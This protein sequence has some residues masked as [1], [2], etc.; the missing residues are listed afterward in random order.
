MVLRLLISMPNVITKVQLFPS[1]KMKEEGVLEAIPRS[2]GI[3]QA[4][5]IMTETHFCFP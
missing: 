3:Q 4:M 2:V 5:D 1:S